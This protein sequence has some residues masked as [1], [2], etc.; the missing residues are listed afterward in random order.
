[1]QFGDRPLEIEIERAQLIAAV[2]RHYVEL[3]RLV[4]GA[5]VAG[6][7]IELRLSPRIAA[8]PGLLDRLGTLRDCE[9]RVLPRGAAAFGTLQYE[10]TIAGRTRS[11]WSITCRSRALRAA[12]HRLRSRT[13][14]PR[15]CGPTHLLFQGRALAHLGA[16]ARDR[17]VGRQRHRDR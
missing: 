13:Q 4:Q 2:E 12:R 7:Q 8:F 1:M 10:A 11:R 3:L 5:R 15:R 9:I 17:L 16:T 6:M 14:R